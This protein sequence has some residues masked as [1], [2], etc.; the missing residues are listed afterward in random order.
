MQVTN[1]FDR[2]TVKQYF[3]LKDKSMYN[4]LIKYAN[5]FTDSVNIFNIKPLHN[6]SFDKVRQLQVLFSN[7]TFFNL[8][9]VFE[10]TTDLRPGDIFL[11]DFFKFINHVKSEIEII[12]NLESEKLSGSSDTDIFNELGFFCQISELSGGNPALQK[13]IENTEYYRC[14]NE[15]LYRKK[16]YD[17]QNSKLRKVK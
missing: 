14:F 1:S 6:F 3:D 17:Y 7:P 13:E 2:I 8:I 4:F 16:K 9:K 10:I 11:D 12:N 5:I 15:L